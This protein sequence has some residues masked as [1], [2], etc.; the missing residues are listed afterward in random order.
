[1]KWRD[2]KDTL[3]CGLLVDFEVPK[4]LLLTQG[5]YYGTGFFRYR[6]LPS[7]IDDGEV[8][9]EKLTCLLKKD[10]LNEYKVCTSYC[11][12]RIASS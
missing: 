12:V 9:S 3:L 5:V 10:N 1:M 6:A 11:D 7:E 4:G 8:C 2:S